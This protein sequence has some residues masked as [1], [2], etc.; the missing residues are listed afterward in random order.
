VQ[1]PPDSRSPEYSQLRHHDLTDAICIPSL[2][3]VPAAI[4]DWNQGA[5]EV[6]SADGTTK[7]S[8]TPE[9]VNI[10]SPTVNIVAPAINMTGAVSV[11]G[12]LVA[13]GAVNGNGIQLEAHVHSGVIRGGAS[14]DG[15][16]G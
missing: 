6:R 2:L 15:P 10:T 1:N 14:T 7:V 11:T 13:T 8:V 16:S 9:E 12:S 4:P 3:C 5:I